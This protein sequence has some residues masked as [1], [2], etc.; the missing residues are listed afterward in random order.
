M[1]RKTSKK[2]ATKTTTKKKSSP[3]K[4][5]KK[6][7]GAKKA[8]TKTKKPKKATK[9]TA[10]QAEKLTTAL[11]PGS[12]SLGDVQITAVEGKDAED[13]IKCRLRS[14]LKL[15]PNI[16]SRI[17]RDNDPADNKPRYTFFLNKDHVILKKVESCNP[18]GLFF[19]PEQSV[20]VAS[21]A[22]PELLGDPVRKVRVKFF[23]K[24]PLKGTFTIV[25]RLKYQEDF[26]NS[27]QEKPRKIGIFIKQL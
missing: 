10:K 16:I 11:P 13:N 3:S 4:A 2:K 24:D 25:F 8:S 27:G 9:T 18:D 26:S 19:I 1:T 23:L 12:L 14:Q 7:A 20:N 15:F 21:I 5:A 6:G 17:D 22:R